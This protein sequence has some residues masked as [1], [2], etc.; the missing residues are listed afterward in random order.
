MRRFFEPATAPAWLKPVLSSIRAA[1]GD[2][3]DVPVRPFQS[4]SASLPPAGEHE[5]GLAYETGVG[6]L[7][8]SNGAT[9]LTLVDTSSAAFTGNVTVG[10]IFGAA[11]NA[12]FGGNVTLGD[13]PGDSHTVNGIAT[14]VHASTTP[15]TSTSYPLQFSVSG[16]NRLTLG[17]DGTNS[18]IQSWAS[19]PLKINLQGN[20]VTLVQDLHSFSSTGVAVTGILS[21]TGNASLGDAAGDS[22]LFKGTTQIAGSEGS[23]SLTIDRI[24]SIVGRFRL[25]VGDGTSFTADENYIS[26]LNTSLH[27]LCGATGTTEVAKF[28]SGGLDISSGKTI[29]V[30][31]TQVVTSRRTG[32]GAMTGTAARTA[33]AVHASQ[34]ISSPPTQTQVQNIDNSLVIVAQR[35]KALIDD[36][37]A[38]GL[39]GA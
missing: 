21:C 8:C 37:N 24:G 14:L 22:H 32:W 6:L 4:A 16:S 27:I 35:L 9:W 36:L 30:N 1:L 34:T 5:G 20:S 7:R 18:Y 10:G 12:T 17:A 15:G 33:G 25:F 3:W 28:D 19:Q 38:H 39:I 11:G 13:A 23:S 31:G 29:E 2:V 26:N